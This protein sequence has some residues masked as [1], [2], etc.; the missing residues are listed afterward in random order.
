MKGHLLVPVAGSP[1][2][3][4]VCTP[5]LIFHVLVNHTACASPLSQM[6]GAPS[7]PPLPPKGSILLILPVILFLNSPPCFPAALLLPCLCLARPP[8]VRSAI[9]PHVG[10]NPEGPSEALPEQWPNPPVPRRAFP[11]LTLPFPGA[12]PATRLQAPH[13]P[14]RFCASLHLHL[15]CPPGRCLCLLL[16]SSGTPL[17]GQPFFS[18]A[19]LT[20]F[21]AI[22]LL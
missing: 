19:V 2:L 20:V 22:T 14:S 13:A 21:S 18:C 9:A 4:K 8:G 1:S 12:S 10:P 6:P 17:L 16:D 5:A 15:T 7:T 11:R 3:Y